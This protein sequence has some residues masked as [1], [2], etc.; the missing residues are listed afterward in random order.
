MV[1]EGRLCSLRCTTATVTTSPNGWVWQQKQRADSRFR[2]LS[3]FLLHEDCDML[4]VLAYLICCSCLL[5]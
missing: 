1:R 3:P 2:G 5:T 4:F